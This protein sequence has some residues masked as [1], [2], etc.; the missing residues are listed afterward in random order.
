YPPTHN[1]PLNT[2]GDTAFLKLYNG[3]DWVWVRASLLHTDIKNEETPECL[4][5]AS[6]Q[7]V[8]GIYR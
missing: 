5:Q 7:A 2:E 6:M 4:R 1:P 8:Y 3:R